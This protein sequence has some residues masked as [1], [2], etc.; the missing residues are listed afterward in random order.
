[1]EKEKK[2]WLP[3]ETAVI[4]LLLLATLKAKV[5][6][7]PKAIIQKIAELKKKGVTIGEI[8][9]ICTAGGYESPSIRRILGAF[10]LEGL[11]SQDYPTVLITPSGLRMFKKTVQELFEIDPGAL[12]RI[13]EEVGVELSEIM[14]L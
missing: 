13:A 10:Y 6:S 14:K 5:E 11:L 12:L 8:P 7:S 4:C 1:M 9:T 2:Y 3:I